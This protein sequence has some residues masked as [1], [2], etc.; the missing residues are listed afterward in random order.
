MALTLISRTARRVGIACTAMNGTYFYPNEGYRALT[1]G[2]GHMARIRPPAGVWTVTVESAALQDVSPTLSSD[3]ITAQ[4]G[5]VTF[6]RYYD[7]AESM[8]VRTTKQG[9]TCTVVLEEAPPPL[10]NCKILG[11]W[12]RW[13]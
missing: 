3:R 13:R 2:T 12:S 5:R 6:T 9:A 4:D 11:W 8:L 10:R 1:N 7:G